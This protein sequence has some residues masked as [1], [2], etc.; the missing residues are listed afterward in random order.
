[1]SCSSSV[2]VHA[3]GGSGTCRS[4]KAAIALSDRTRRAGCTRWRRAAAHVR[5]PTSSVRPN[6]TRGRAPT[7]GSRPCTSTGRPLD[8]GVVRGGSGSADAKVAVAPDGDATCEVVEV[9]GGAD[10]VDGWAD[11]ARRSLLEPVGELLL[12]RL[13]VLVDVEGLLVQRGAAATNDTAK[14]RTIPQRTSPSRESSLSRPT[15]RHAAGS[16]SMTRC[17]TIAAGSKSDGPSYTPGDGNEAAIPCVTATIPCT[18]TRGATAPS[19][20][21]LGQGHAARCPSIRCGPMAPPARRAHSG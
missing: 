18:R 11:L 16:S 14:T 3:A 5:S 12:V 9:H 19:R 17:I 10:A 2:P 1:M 4:R 6:S 21:P 8:D 15:I 20:P 13:V 7:R